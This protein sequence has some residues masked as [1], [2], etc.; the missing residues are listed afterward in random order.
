MFLATQFTAVLSSGSGG[1]CV[2]ITLPGVSGLEECLD[3]SR[4]ECSSSQGTL[5]KLSP[6][7]TCVFKVLADASTTDIALK[8]YKDVVGTLV[9]AA[10]NPL[11]LSFRVSTNQIQGTVN[12]SGCDGT[13]TVSLPNNVA[14]K[15]ATDLSDACDSP[16]KKKL[17]SKLVSGVLCFVKNGLQ[18]ARDDDIKSIICDVIKAI[19]DAGGAQT[20]LLNS[21]IQDI[22]NEICIGPTAC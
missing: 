16:A 12:L 1:S 19:N 10:C 11:A 22:N 14:N 21:V 18:G 9:A 4:V 20:F 5:Q 3:D 2:D 6:V 8:T 7:V 13:V 15:C 17:T